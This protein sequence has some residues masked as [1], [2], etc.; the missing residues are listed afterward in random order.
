MTQKLLLVEANDNA[1]WVGARV[2]PKIHVLPIALMGLAAHV[3]SLCSDLEVRIIETSLH[4]PSNQALQSVIEDFRP[5][6]IG[7]RSI[8]L[9]IDEVRRVIGVAKNCTEAPV[10][11]G[12]P[13][14]TALGT[15][16]F[17]DVAGLEFIAVGEGEPVLAALVSGVPLAEI[18]GVHM[19]AMGA[20]PRT[21]GEPVLRLARASDV[22]GPLPMAPAA[23]KAS[24]KSISLDQLAFPSYELVDL[25]QYQ[26]ALSYAYNHRRQ[27]VLVTSR[28]CPFSCTYCFQISDAPARLQS[29]ERVTHDIRQ[30]RDDFG[31]ED[32]YFVDDLFNLNRKRA[33]QVFDRIIEANVS[34]RLYFVNGLRVDLCDEP[35]IERMVEA[36]T[37]WV[38][39]A[40]ESAC[41]RI[42]ALIRKEIDLSRARRLINFTQRQ[43]IVVNVN[44][45]FGFP[46]ETPEE[47]QMTLDYLG[48]LDHPSLLPYH[49]NLRGYPGCE[50]V[51]Q[52]ERAGWQRDAFLATGFYS[53]GD[54]PAGSP[55]FSRREMLQHLLYFHEH[56][57][58]ANRA[59]LDYSVRTLRHIGYRDAE[60]VD[61]YTV[62]TNRQIH[63]VDELLRVPQ[64]ASAL[65]WA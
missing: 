45:M 39:Y 12:G 38:T 6:W 25:D 55:T 15:Q 47:A 37:V 21:S 5:T 65:H 11:L 60:I 43:G 63:S 16:L 34:V 33:L 22:P 20:L 58:L 36:G 59:H 10:L 48:S 42:Q 24:A 41:P 56:Y 18:P 2:G 40:I 28:G 57:G 13:I 51:E 53:Y 1:R 29:A 3:K 62:L 26:H 52:A 14:A 31:V 4:T 30:L 49:F 46:T 61:M 17:D 19:R 23:S 9:F 44:T 64:D 7:I 27:G 54:L 50:I 32:F 35:F 8:S